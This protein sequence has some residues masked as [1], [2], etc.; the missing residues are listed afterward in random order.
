MQL[1]RWLRLTMFQGINFTLQQIWS[2]AWWVKIQY[3]AIFNSVQLIVFLDHVLLLAELGQNF[4][5]LQNSC[6][7]K[8]FHETEL[9]GNF[10]YPKLPCRLSLW[11]WFSQWHERLLPQGSHQNQQLSHLTA[12]NTQHL[13]KKFFNFRF[14]FFLNFEKQK[15]M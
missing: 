7:T 5:F 10:I 1:K 11:I 8:W 13:K 9:R 6:I 12:L 15:K 4:K 2:L 14:F 3:I